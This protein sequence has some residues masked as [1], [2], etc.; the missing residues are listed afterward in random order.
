M[1]PPS[2]GGEKPCLAPCIRCGK[3]INDNAEYC[4]ACGTLRAENVMCINHPETE[5]LGV[6]VVCGESMCAKCG[7][8][9]DGRFHCKR[10]TP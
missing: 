9:S 2:I 4:P 7:G 8:Y 10:H 5:A 3:M 1:S 6:C